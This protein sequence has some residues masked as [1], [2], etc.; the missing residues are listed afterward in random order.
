MGRGSR[1]TA[2]PTGAAARPDDRRYS[3][4]RDLP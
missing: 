3:G 2:C 1:G 4:G